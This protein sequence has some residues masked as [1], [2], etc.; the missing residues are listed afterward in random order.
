ML[1]NSIMKGKIKTKDICPQ[2]KM[3]V[4]VEQANAISEVALPKMK[5]FS[6]DYIDFD[7]VDLS[8]EDFAEDQNIKKMIRNSQKRGGRYALA[9][10]N[11]FTMD[12]ELTIFPLDRYNMEAIADLK[13]S[14]LPEKLIVAGKELLDRLLNLTKLPSSEEAMCDTYPD[15]LLHAVAVI[16]NNSD[17]LILRKRKIIP[18]LE[19]N[20]KQDIYAYDPKLG[21]LPQLVGKDIESFAETLNTD[22][23]Q[24]KQIQEQL[25]KGRDAN[26][27]EFLFK[28][29]LAKV[30]YYLNPCKKDFEVA[31]K[32][33]GINK[34]T[35]LNQV[36][37]SALDEE[38]Y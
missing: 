30:G 12:L 7:K 20:Q 14:N 31:N 6:A 3:Y 23:D 21:K 5:Y 19:W 1:K 22:L 17:K 29:Y 9:I 36:I 2:D 26:A 34:E 18:G 38:Q 4:Q 37:D 27:S 28:T 8:D 32:K 15:T 13:H 33:V 35:N 24:D 10:N 16:K 11:E 25:L